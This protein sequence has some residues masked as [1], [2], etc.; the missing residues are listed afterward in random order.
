[1]ARSIKNRFIWMFLLGAVFAALIASMGVYG[2]LMDRESAKQ[3]YDE[4][5]AIVNWFSHLR[6]EIRNTR[7]EL[8][9]MTIERET[10]GMLVHKTNM[11]LL[12][13]D[14]TADFDEFI[15]SGHLR[16]REGVLSKLLEA[17]SLW[18]E[19]LETR[20]NE[21]IPFMLEGKYEKAMDFARG[22]QQERYLKIMTLLDEVTSGINAY[23][24]EREKEAELKGRRLVSGIAVMM[25]LGLASGTAVFYA[26]SADIIK[27]INALRKGAERISM[28][29]F[30]ARAGIEGEDEIASL[31]ETFDS[32]AAR[33]QEDMDL[34]Q[35]S[36]RELQEKNARLNE[37]MIEAKQYSKV[38]EFAAK[39]REE[40]NKKLMDAVEEAEAANRQLAETQTKLLQSE[41]MA[42]IGQLAA[43][44]A[45]EI[46]NPIGFVN[47]NMS[48]LSAYMDDIKELMGKYEEL[49]AACRD[50]GCGKGMEFEGDIRSFRNKKDIEFVFDD[51]SK[52]IAE[53]RD[54]LGRVTTII[55]D[56]RSFSHSSEADVEEFDV[57]EG[58]ES[59]LNIVWNQIKYSADVNKECGDIP[60]IFGYPQQLNQVF[61]N[62]LLNAAHALE[63]RDGKG[64]IGIRT[65]NGGE[66]VF[67]E[68]SD[69]GC[70]IPEDKLGKIFDPFFTT[71]PVGKG[72]GLGLSLAYNIVKKHKGEISVKSR[73]GE[74][75]T[76]T[77]KLPVHTARKELVADGE[78][79]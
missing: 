40:Q 41:K 10:E 43:G 13:E 20:Y 65:Y 76:F 64:Q 58:I 12:D 30:S 34:I 29:D 70:G 52:L 53:S 46:N 7:V 55:K 69:N 71:K 23:L 47:G 27:R 79:I 48:T 37:A 60:V 33:I 73:V 14:I 50:G 31:G 74:G 68:I 54:G 4:N 1:M 67:V 44:V 2:I 72:T 18:K 66:H 6:E 78:G 8:V 62:I 35:K 63:G 61:M 39:E 51:L 11:E 49:V 19:F 28:G 16:G 36:E 77:I 25:A 75:T 9:T 38:M 32:M 3:F 42:S 15:K 21:I 56:L 17:Q 59:T 45:H 57:N 22:I 26:Y 5:A 24:H